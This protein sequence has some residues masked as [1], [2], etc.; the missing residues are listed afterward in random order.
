MAEPVAFKYRA[1][2]SYSHADTKWAKWLHRGL[3]TFRIDKDLVGRD[4][5]TGT[6]PD[7]LRPIFRD[8]DD[9]T[10]GHSLTEQT[11]AALDASAAVVVIC[12]P[13]SA[14]S[15]YVNE[16]IRLFKVRH[17]KRPVIP[18][19]VEGRPDDAERECFPDALKFK[20]GPKGRVSKTKVEML[21]ADAR[22][23]GDGKTL[24]LAKV[25][26]GLLGLSADDVFRRAERE[27]RR[28]GRLRNGIIGV[29]AFLAIAATASAVYAWQ[30]LKT[31]EAF[32]TATLKT[33]TE[34][35]DDAVAQATRYGVPRTATLAL[36]TKA[37]AL[38]DNMALLGR[39][40]RELRY[41]KAWML[42]Q[43][44]RNYEALG[45]TSKWK[46]RAE[47]AQAILTALVD[48]AP[49]DLS[50]R[51]DLVIA[52]VE[53][54]DVLFTQGN[55]PRALDSYEQ[56]SATATDLVKERPDSGALQHVL[57]VSRERVGDVHMARGKLDA[58][59]A[60]Y[61]ESLAVAE[62]LAAAA[63]GD[64]GD[65]RGLAVS[66]NKI[67]DVQM[68]RGGLNEALG[69]YRQALAITEKLA[70]SDPVN[71]SWQRDLSVDYNRV[72]IVQRAQGNLSSALE[73]FRES[74]AIRK[75]LAA[76]DPS[77]AI[78]QK[79]LATSL[80]HVGDA[81]VAQGKLD[82]ALDSFKESLVID[83]R[84]VASDSGNAAWQ[85]SLSISHNKIG[86]VLLAQGKPDLAEASF[87][88]GLAIAEALA[89]SDPS[90]AGWQRSL[91]VSQNKVG[92]ALTMQVDLDAAL[93]TFEASLVIAERL[94]ATAPTNGEWQTDLSITH[95]KIGDVKKLQGDL[96]AALVSF[97]ESSGDRRPPRQIR[98]RQR[99]LA[100]RRFRGP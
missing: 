6:V 41:Q 97:R 36:L 47:E 30:Q 62:R 91:S 27:R 39:P 67:G 44:A 79:D 25:V 83:E 65:Q 49:D 45:D 32:L 43:F 56:A 52:N 1:F 48:D 51:R 12:S 82:D 63:P 80:D 88:K 94:A 61:K 71:A 92:E 31:N 99:E 69:A 55:L 28:K 17:P 74:L 33:A 9:F 70:N 89:E 98:S 86:D 53:I 90:N 7:V 58:A 18:L 50:R 87:R 85:A 68:A 34:I 76:I 66:Y 24:A 37:E 38:F 57:A 73:A 22:E 54:G 19:I 46:A 60:S 3:E 75:R 15:H 23:E 20:V 64:A 21:A 26:A 59:L 14:K 72:A 100:A 84:L 95:N 16:E 35:V 4:T 13:A 96:D 93:A 2:I 40:T 78:W 5:A 11:L 10:A 29:L 81:L 77:N 42:I 8:R